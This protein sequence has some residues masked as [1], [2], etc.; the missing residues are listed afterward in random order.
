M[1]DQPVL[2]SGS[3]YIQIKYKKKLLATRVY[4]TKTWWFSQNIPKTQ[5]GNFLL[6]RQKLMQIFLNLSL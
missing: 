1:L 2:A 3:D 4:F 6:T 5:F